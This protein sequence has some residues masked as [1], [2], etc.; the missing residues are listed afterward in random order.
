M[1]WLNRQVS[2]QGR[3]NKILRELWLR[4]KHV[5]KPP[6]ILQYIIIWTKFY[7]PGNLLKMNSFSFWTFHYLLP[8]PAGICMLSVNIIIARKKNLFCMT[9]IPKVI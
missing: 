5:H 6:E 3:G 1:K 8:I 7:K 4:C 9:M 2:L